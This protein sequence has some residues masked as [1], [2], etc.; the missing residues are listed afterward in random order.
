MPRVHCFLKTAG[1]YCCLGNRKVTRII[2][3]HQ[4]HD[5]RL[6]LGLEF[7]VSELGCQCAPVLL[8]S[9]RCFFLYTRAIHSGLIIQPANSLDLS[10]SVLGPMK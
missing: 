10:F 4:N 5:A 2:T 3:L 8:T 7:L 6:G 1:V 9:T